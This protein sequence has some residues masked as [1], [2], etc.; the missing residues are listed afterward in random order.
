MITYKELKNK[1]AVAFTKVQKIKETDR[2]E[3]E[4]AIKRYDI[5]T[6]ERLEDI[7]I[8]H[9]IEELNNRK[10][11]LINQRKILFADLQDVDEML[12]DISKSEKV[13]K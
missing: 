2:D 8:K 6:G 9:S 10:A 1:K 3:Y 5:S 11:E 13:N 4:F 12:A 7:K